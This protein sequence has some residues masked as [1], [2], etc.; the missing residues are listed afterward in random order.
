[1]Q[2]KYLS[3]SYYVKCG[4]QVF[5]K[6]QNYKQKYG[7]KFNIFQYYCIQ[8]DLLFIVYIKDCLEVI[9]LQISLQIVVN[10]KIAYLLV[11]NICKIYSKSKILSKFSNLVFL[12]VGNLLSAI[13]CSFK[14]QQNLWF[15]YLFYL[16]MEFGK[17]LVSLKKIEQQINWLPE[18]ITRVYLQLMKKRKSKQFVLPF[19]FNVFKQMLFYVH[20]FCFR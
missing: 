19:R 2:N 14:Q 13:F 12:N 20:V 4:F 18:Q 5:G 17:F 6:R 7:K 16:N 1:M 10:H 8:F 11:S 15:F 3:T 9:Y